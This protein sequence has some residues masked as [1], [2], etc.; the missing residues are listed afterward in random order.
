MKFLLKHIR[1]LIWN[2]VKIF[3]FFKLIANSAQG[4]FI[5]PI[6]AIKSNDF[7]HK[8]LYINKCFE[9]DIYLRAVNFLKDKD[10]FIGKKVKNNFQY[11]SEN[12][13]HFL[14]VDEIKKLLNN[15]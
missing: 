14:K 13:S 5:I 10:G 7:I 15:I 2:F 6:E 11:D 3:P 9:Y 4:D 1:T 12:N 8:S